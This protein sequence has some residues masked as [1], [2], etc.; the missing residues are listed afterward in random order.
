MKL[1]ELQTQIDLQVASGWGDSEV[2]AR[3]GEDYY[4][5]SDF[6]PSNAEGTA[7]HCEIVLGRGGKR[8]ICARCAKYDGCPN[9]APAPGEDVPGYEGICADCREDRRHAGFDHGGTV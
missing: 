1:R 4:A 9:A 3:L 8:C 7:D 5:V 2:V 6:N